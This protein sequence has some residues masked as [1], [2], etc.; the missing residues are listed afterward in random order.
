M[1]GHLRSGSSGPDIE[2]VQRALNYYL[3]PPLPP[4]RVDGRFGALTR[5]RVL[6]F[7]RQLHLRHRNGI[8]DTQTR[9]ALFPLRRMT[10]RTRI[11]PHSSSP[12]VTT[13][14]SGPPGP[15]PERPWPSN[16]E[17][18]HFGLANVQVQTGWQRISVRMQSG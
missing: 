3:C 1:S 13:A 18:P 5:D 4:L 17:G 12:P 11:Q 16:S 9:R 2:V 10:L 8:I 15:A 6:E 7:Q 14:T